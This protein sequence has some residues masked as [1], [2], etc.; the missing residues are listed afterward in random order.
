MCLTVPV[1]IKKIEN[2]SAIVENDRGNFKVDTSLIKD[3]KIN[4]WLLVHAN[5]AI[6]KI[7]K[8]EALNINKLLYGK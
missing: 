5:L 3:I 8:K 1:K 7:S 4:D 6:K 2:N